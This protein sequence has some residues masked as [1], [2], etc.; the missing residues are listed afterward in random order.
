[1]TDSLR[2]R[3]SCV[4]LVA[5][6]V[7]SGSACAVSD[8]GTHASSLDAKQAWPQA[9]IVNATE[10]ERFLSHGAM[11]VELEAISP[12]HGCTPALCGADQVEHYELPVPEGCTPGRCSTRIDTAEWDGEA[13]D[14]RVVGGGQIRLRKVSAGPAPEL[15]A[16]PLAAWRVHSAGQVWGLCMEF[17]HEGLGRSGRA[18]RWASLLLLPYREGR[19]ADEAW[20]FTGYWASCGVLRSGVSAGAIELPLIEPAQGAQVGLSLERYHCDRLACER[21]QASQRLQAGDD[22]RLLRGD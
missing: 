6:Q 2:S 16:E 19:P 3:L 15:D 14:L 22:G 20:R 4:A 10:L 7:L 17:A 9:G 8:T 11:A 13:T 5:A 12:E 18:Q 1:M 21:T